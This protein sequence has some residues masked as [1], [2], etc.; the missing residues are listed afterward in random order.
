[1]KS[2]RRCPSPVRLALSL[3]VLASLLAAIGVPLLVQAQDAGDTVV[4]P[5]AGLAA[6]VLAL[7]STRP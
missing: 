3:L 6:G 1:M 5:A 2:P 4:L 7:R